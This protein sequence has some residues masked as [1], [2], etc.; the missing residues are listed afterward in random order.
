[1][2]LS[3]AKPDVGAT[4]IVAVST[5][6]VALAW[7]DVLQVSGARLVHCFATSVCTPGALWPAS[8]SVAVKA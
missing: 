8:G 1:V 2:N 5:W 4:L 3:A 6:Y 7:L